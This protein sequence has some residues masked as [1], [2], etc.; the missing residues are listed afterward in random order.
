MEC[1]EWNANIGVLVVVDS[2]LCSAGSGVLG[3]RCWEWSVGSGV[4]VVQC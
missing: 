2:C 4:L 3:V 1:R